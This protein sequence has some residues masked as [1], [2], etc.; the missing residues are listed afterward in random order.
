[1]DKK[2]MAIGAALMGLL[3]FWAVQARNDSARGVAERGDAPDPK[4]AAESRRAFE[5]AL[6]QSTQLLESGR[7]IESARKLYHVYPGFESYLQS[8]G[9]EE[10]ERGVTLKAWFEAKK[11][12]F[13]QAIS[14]RYPWM[15]EQLKSGDLT[16]REV[17][18]FF[19]EMPFPFIHELRRTYEKEKREISQAR[20]A[21]GTNWCYLCV[22]GVSGSSEE[23]ERMVRAILQKRWNPQ[24][25]LKLLFDNPA[26]GEE[27]RAAGKIIDVRIEEKFAEY[28]FQND[29][30]R[31][32]GK[33]A[34]S[35]IVRF[36]ARHNPNAR[37]K[38]NWESLEAIIVTNQAPE[39]LS[40]K[41]ENKY[42]SADFSGIASRQ[43]QALEQKLSVALES[44]P[45]LEVLVAR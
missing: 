26:S 18:T 42:Q 6:E 9:F 39:V 13:V 16:W 7:L 2:L 37:V 19:G 22:L 41:L 21:Q 20:A 32:V 45:P 24:S 25:G 4:N 12:G 31:G 15:V 27:T 29:P 1:M 11:S 44:L 8:Q 10:I 36:S 40:F 14:N 34:E 28:G 5:T 23:Y 35:T 33:V 43:R 17:N 38:T 3:M 30:S